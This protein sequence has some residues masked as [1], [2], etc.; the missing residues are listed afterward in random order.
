[1]RPHTILCALALLSLGGCAASPPTKPDPRD[2]WERVNRA[3]YAFND[4]V[5]RAI[6]KPAARA[7]R[8][9]VPRIA[10]RGVSNF[11]ANLEQP[12]V[13]VNDLLQGK[14]R[15]AGNDAARF[16]LNTTLGLGG[17]FDPASPAGLDRNDEDF[18]QTLGKWGVRS[19]PYLMLP[20][21]GPA[22]VRDGVG[23]VVDQLTEPDT[24]VKDDKVLW[25]AKALG[26]LEQRERLLDLEPALERTFDKYAFIRN[27]YLQRREY[28]VSDGAVAEEE[29]PPEEGEFSEEEL[30][31]AERE[32]GMVE[33]PPA[34][35]PRPDEPPPQAR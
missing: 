22:T 17:L 5:D 31:E 4:R 6:A 7:Y 20:F 27:A 26:L 19:G 29:A 24:Y 12:T 34:E 30:E 11:F 21:L 15:P 9:V 3:T 32:S 13:M 25:S 23:D 2:P 16:L 28:L 10:R 8:K 14:W 33:E 18:G 1:M 35:E